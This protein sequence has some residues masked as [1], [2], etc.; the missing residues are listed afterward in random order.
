M[1]QATWQ[2]GHSLAQTVYACLYLHMPERMAPNAILH[3]YCK[4]ARST[5]NLVRTL[6]C[7]ADIHEVGET[8]SMILE[9]SHE[10]FKWMNLVPDAR[11]LWSRLDC[12][13]RLKNWSWS[14]ALEEQVPLWFLE[15]GS[16]RLLFCL[17][18]VVVSLCVSNP[19]IDAV[20][21]YIE[22]DDKEALPLFLWVY[23]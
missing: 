2:S 1:M 19:S 3:A 23:N 9:Q 12:T 8:G 13:L 10:H 17:H 18:P 6:V 21:Q 4:M 14:A 7:V 20:S 11:R 22:T 16:V 15:E 5:C